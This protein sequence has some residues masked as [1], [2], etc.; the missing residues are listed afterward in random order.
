MPKPFLQ[1][2]RFSSLRIDEFAGLVREVVQVAERRCAQVGLPPV[3][4]AVWRPIGEAPGHFWVTEGY[5]SAEEWGRAEDIGITDPDLR[6]A[7]ADMSA[8]GITIDRVLM[9]AEFDSLGDDRDEHTHM[10]RIIFPASAR[11]DEITNVFR[12]AYAEARKAMS[13]RALLFRARVSGDA[14]NLWEL[15]LETPRGLTADVAGHWPAPLAVT[16]HEAIYRSAGLPRVK[17]I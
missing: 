17:A 11:Q 6:S 4:W 15:W 14:F 7:I 8:A 5:G 1:I 3:T 10:K 9:L 13:C 16:Q 2:N 12:E